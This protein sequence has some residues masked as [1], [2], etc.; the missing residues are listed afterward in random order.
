MWRTY[1]AVFLLAGMLA[2]GYTM[3]HYTSE[4]ALTIA[5]QIPVSLSDP[6]AEAALDQAHRQFQRRSTLFST[7]YVHTLVEGIDP[8]FQTCL[9]SQALGQAEDY[10]GQAAMLRYLLTDL[11]TR[12]DAS[13]ANIL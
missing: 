5:E 11:S 9:S 13:L 2:A 7:F 4:Q 12:D 8:E 10:A 6:Q 3:H 1:L